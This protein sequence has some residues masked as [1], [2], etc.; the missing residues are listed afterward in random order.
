MGTVSSVSKEINKTMDSQEESS[1]FELREIKYRKN[2]ENKSHGQSET[3]EDTKVTIVNEQKIPYKF[4]WKEGGNNVKIAGSFLDNWK[5]KIDMKK[6]PMSGI[7]EII[8]NIP[9]GIHQFKFIVDNQ[10]RCSQFHKIIYDKMN[11]ANNIIDLSNYIPPIIIE[12]SPNNN[13]K[14]KKKPGKEHIDYS[15]DFPNLSEVNLE[16]PGVPNHYIPEFN[17]NYEIK[18]EFVQLYKIGFVKIN[19]SKSI[20]ENNT[21]KSITT[22]SHEKLSHVCINKDNDN[23]DKYI[24]TAISQRN[25]HKFITIVYY[26]PKK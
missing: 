2:M 25:R 7:F 13:K 16:A 19:K 1:E 12:N 6:N 10:W 3:R 24:K 18:Q 11:N 15:C 8:L 26:T 14:K 22:I 4:E 23:N 9:K 20:L 21:F 5:I 17:I